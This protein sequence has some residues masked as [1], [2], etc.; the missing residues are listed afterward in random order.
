[1]WF[2]LGIVPLL[3][4]ILSYPQLLAGTKGDVVGYL[5][6]AL[7]V[8]SMAVASIYVYKNSINFKSIFYSFKTNV[9]SKSESI[10]EEYHSLEAKQKQT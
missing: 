9:R 8:F 5:I 2:G 3:S 6:V 4:F 10:V 1:M 7:L